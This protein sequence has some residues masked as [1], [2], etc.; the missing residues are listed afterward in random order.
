[1]S[2][3]L[4]LKHNL[5]IFSIPLSVKFKFP[6][7]TIHLH[8]LCCFYSCWNTVLNPHLSFLISNLFAFSFP[9]FCSFLLLLSVLRQHPR[10]TCFPLLNKV[11]KTALCFLQYQGRCQ[12]KQLPSGIFSVAQGSCP[13]SSEKEYLTQ[14]CCLPFGLSCVTQGRMEP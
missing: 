11:W 9:A 7:F 14:S 4:I 13:S 2:C 5:G 10:K 8:S 6:S 3:H 12:G 1:M